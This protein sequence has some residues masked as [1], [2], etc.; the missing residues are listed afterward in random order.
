M[1]GNFVSPLSVIGAPR[2]E[3][4]QGHLSITAL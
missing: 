2:V 4:H 1:G 3:I